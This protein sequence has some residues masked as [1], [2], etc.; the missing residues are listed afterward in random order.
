MAATEPRWPRWAR[1][2][3]A[4]A[5]PLLKLLGLTALATPAAR[6]VDLPQ[7]HEE[8]LIHLYNGG[9]V[10]AYGPALLVR[11]SVA[12]KVSLT[13][14]V[15]VDM[16][17]NASI[18]VVTTASPFRENRVEWGLGVDHVEQDTLMH[19][20]VSRST[21]PDYVASAA[22]L[23]VSQDVFGGMSTVALGFTLGQDDVGRHGETGYFDHARHWQY[24]L[25][26]TQI[27]SPRWIASVNGEAIADEGYL[28]NPYRVAR[29]FGAYVPERMPR[30]RT[31]RALQF[32]V[33]GDISDEG[34]SDRSAVRA[35]YRYYRDTWAVQ[36]H[37]LELGYT[38][39]FGPDWLGDVALRLNH[40]GAALF[41]RDNAQSETLY[42]TRN[43][44]LSAFNSYA[45]AGKLSYTLPG[46]TAQRYGLQLNAN[47]ELLSFHYSEFTD[48]RTGQLYHFNGQ[49]LQLLL[50]GKF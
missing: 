29:V 41:F 15:Y 39:H 37:T 30:T 49:N 36:A 11:K 23:D 21:E 34:A 13:G 40:Q 31:A 2:L 16:V 45:L 18:D 20:G 42:V 5:A 6:A 44:Q 8:A 38:R 22:N 26:L 9:G 3:W 14:S 50:T 48:I 33:I 46:E 7:D 19:L 28:G 24:R 4:V 47:L 27:L 35:S 17:S 12:D 32:R 10:K 43:R 1:A 25:G